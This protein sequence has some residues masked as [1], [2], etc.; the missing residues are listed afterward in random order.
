MRPHAAHH[1]HGRSR[2]AAGPQAYC[3]ACFALVDAEARACPVCG[4]DLT[5]LRVRAYR[6]KLLAALNHPLAGVRLRAI[7]ALGWRG[8]SAT[9]QALARCVLRHPVDVVEGLQVLENLRGIQDAAARRR[10]LGMLAERR[11]AR[12]VRRQAAELFAADA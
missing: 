7:I 12:A 11:P 9:A 5:R 8:E 3:P 10:V 4:R 1:H 6:G 2:L